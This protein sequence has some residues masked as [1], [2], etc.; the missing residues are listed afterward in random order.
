M[1]RSKL[2]DWIEQAEARAYYELATAEPGRVKLL[3]GSAAVRCASPTRVAGFICR[4]RRQLH[5]LDRARA[6]A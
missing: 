3:P 6:A 2:I 1:D 5:A 4:L